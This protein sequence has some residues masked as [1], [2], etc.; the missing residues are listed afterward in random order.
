LLC[1]AEFARQ[2]HEKDRDR[3]EKDRDCSE[4]TREIRDTD[5]FSV[6]PGDAT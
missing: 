3:G 4:Y 2:I 6:I 1:W 5:W